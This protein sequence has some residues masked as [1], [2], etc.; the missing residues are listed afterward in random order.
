V[1]DGALAR[2]AALRLGVALVLA[3]TLAACT[4]A[5]PS[6]A[7]I[8]P[9]EA[10]APTG[11]V[12][13]VADVDGPPI[14]IQ[15]GGH[16]VA[17]V[18]CS[19]YT[20][21]QEGVGGVPDLPWSLDVRRQGGAL[22]GHFDVYGGPDFT[23]LLRG[24]TVAL[25]QFAAD[26]P[27]ASPGACQRWNG[28]SLPSGPLPATAAPSP[29]W[30]TGLSFCVTPGFYRVNGV[31]RAFGDCAGLL[32]VPPASLTL[33]VGQQVDAHMRTVAPVGSPPPQA[34]DPLPTSTNPAVLRL[35]GVSDGGN[36]ASYR[37]EE[38]GT[39][40]LMSSGWCLHVR[41]QQETSG[42]C[43]ALAVTVSGG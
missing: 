21:L 25:G 19:G 35:V 37:A 28:A 1:R 5:P 29:W 31:V 16:V 24:D 42:A 12:L 18:S 8:G 17:E 15:I 2:R 41:T 11:W 34:I 38:S 10:A 13:N 20:K 30:P 43:P 33:Q 23:L 22:L 40:I 36:T 3:E 39:A 4:S 27:A 9:T 7:V 6:A 14:E 32:F 26:G